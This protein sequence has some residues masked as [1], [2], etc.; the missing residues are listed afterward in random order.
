LG[1]VYN[2]AVGGRMSLN[3]LFESL[4]T[5]V[6]ERH[7]HVVVPAP[8]YEPFRPGDVRHSQAD[9]GKAR[10]LLHYD[11][12]VE[13]RTGLRE[14]LPWYEGRLNRFGGGREE[15]LQRARG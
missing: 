3:A 14:A 10:R 9:I 12:T 1:Q 13:V 7:P 11:P 15:E 8:V 2:V 4:R 6:R 5:L